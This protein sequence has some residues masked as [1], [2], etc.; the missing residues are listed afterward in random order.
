MLLE[1]IEKKTV[2]WNKLMHQFIKYVYAMLCA[3]CYHL[4]NLKN[5]KDSHGGVLLLVKFQSEAFN[6]TKS[7]TPP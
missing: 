2:A 3:I 7:N 6:L 5:V 4:Y 1:I